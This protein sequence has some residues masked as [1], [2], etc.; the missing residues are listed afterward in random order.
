[1]S[2]FVHLHNHSHYSLQDA[3]CTIEG[4][5]KTAKAM[6]MPAVALTDHG[7]L[8]GVREFYRKASD[9][10]LKPIVGMEAYITIGPSRFD[11]TQV[12]DKNGRKR[13]YRHLI[14]LAKNET[15]YRNLCY[16]SS[17]GHLE[18][19]YYRPRIDFD[20]LKKHSEGLIVSTACLGGIVAPHLVD[21][22]FDTALEVARQYKEVF[23]DDFYLELQDHGIADDRAVLEGMPKIA[24]KLGIKMIA[25]ND[26]HYLKQEDAYAHNILLLFGDKT[27]EA[28]YKKLRYGTDQIYFKSQ[29]EMKALF[30]DYK[31]AIENTLEITEKIEYKMGN[32]KFH[33]PNF[34][35]PEEFTD[36]SLDAYLKY[37]A[38]EGL[39]KRYTTLTDEILQRFEFEIKVITDMGFPGYFL[40]VQDFIAAAR[41]L[42]VPVGPGR[43]SAAGSLVA[44][45]LGITNVDPLE[46]D[47]LFERFLNPSRKS[48]PDID[49][50]FSD[51]K[52]DKVIEY[53]KQRYGPECVSQI[54]T[55]NTL[56]SR[57][58]IRD[59]GRVLGVPIMTVNNITKYIPAEF[60]KRYSIEKA[61]EEVPELA[62]IKNTPDETI[63][64]LI[65]YSKVLEGMNRNLSKHAAG[66]VIAPGD[67]RQYVP[68]STV[69]SDADVVTQ[70]N[71]KELE[72]A[73]LL[74]MDFL[75]LRTL[76][77][78]EDTIEMV[79]K[80]HGVTIDIDAIPVDDA[81]TFELFAKGQTTGVFQFESAPMREY[82]KRLRPTSI[83][84]LSAMNALYRP[85]PMKYID[86]FINRKHGKIPITYMHMALETILKETYGI[87]V[88]QEQVIQM[89]NKVAGMSLAEADILR[90]AMGKKDKDAMLKQQS[91]FVQGAVKMGIPEKTAVEI[92]AA[93]EEFANYGFNKSHA[94]AYSVV[95]YQTAYLK[96][97]YTPEFLA[98]NMTNE[99]NT[100]EK[101]AAFLDDCRKLKIPVLPPDFNRPVKYFDVEKGQIWFGLAAIKN[102]GEKAVDFLKAAR[103]KYL[104]SLNEVKP[105]AKS[106]SSGK[107]K[108]APS[109]EAAD[110]NKQ[111]L[112]KLFE[113]LRHTDTQQINKR[114][115]EGLILAG[116]FD[117]LSTNRKFLFDHTE[118]VIQELNK[119]KD[120][121]ENNLFMDA[122]DSAVREPDFPIKETPDWSY[123]ERL[124]KE[125]EVTGFYISDH[126]LNKYEL[127]YRS[128]SSIR[129]GDPETYAN[130]ETVTIVAVVTS[131]NVKID[132]RGNKMAIFTI[133]DFTGSCECIMFSSVY[134]K[135]E[136]FLLQSRVLMFQGRSESSGDSV[137]LHIEEA[138][139]V[140]AAASKYSKY[141]RIQKSLESTDIRY[142]EQLQ[143][144][145][146]KHPGDIPLVL[147]MDIDHKDYKVFILQNCRVKPETR[148]FEELLKI[149]E[150]ES[151][152]IMP[153]VIT[154]KAKEE[155]RMSQFRTQN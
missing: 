119:E 9:A 82:L 37:L 131:V 69:G 88:Y 76:S 51:K 8:Y 28:D 117:T 75:G 113:F 24:K 79:K 89:A 153:I 93:I 87:I 62:P 44:Y 143:A 132:K 15:G 34:P 101:I 80:N 95:A 31:G 77:I 134:Q 39:K 6:N 55:F 27:G 58:V 30:K 137:K 114:V 130:D 147:D 72:S 10:G 115:L 112:I 149:A 150:P 16:L 70:Y 99:L 17:A 20:L 123:E 105:A 84:D 128:F 144:L 41:K 32:D 57:A 45:A 90:R 25:T 152:R 3:A 23:G 56:S 64:D 47:L 154:G 110:S 40:V 127:E 33:F 116:A 2:D 135:C 146:K 102:V 52:R 86:D 100:K 71:M 22:D 106:K 43:G 109:P 124:E 42:G 11:K 7:V 140:S 38:Y 13:N 29:E 54:V 35:V 142:L 68:L 49:I 5:V 108:D 46:Y 139:P 91:I 60:G 1:M 103:E 85:G 125:R 81:K 136:A 121:W 61:L 151:I 155:P 111:A 129:L 94:V 67:V 92:F 104:A 122:N 21:G 19:Y 126:P 12:I 145:A 18:G 65:K 73:G 66:V 59:V 26:C 96:A 97:H 4:L 36:K 138:I 74:K 133:D 63:K 83:K 120:F 53:V 98:A 107:K 14:L 50:D 78:I 148:L 48:M 141:V 118:I